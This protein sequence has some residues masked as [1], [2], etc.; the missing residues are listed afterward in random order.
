MKLGKEPLIPLKEKCSALFE[1]PLEQKRFLK[2][3]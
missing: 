3:I 1:K 2:F